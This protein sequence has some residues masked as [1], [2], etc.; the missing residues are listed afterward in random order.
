MITISP[1]SP[2]LLARILPA[3][4]AK[5][6][7]SVIHV[8][9]FFLRLLL[10]FLFYSYQSLSVSPADLVWRLHVYQRRSNFARSNTTVGGAGFKTFRDLQL[11]SKDNWLFDLKLTLSDYNKFQMHFEVLSVY[12]IVQWILN[13][14]LVLCCSYLITITLLFIFKKTQVASQYLLQS[15]FPRIDMTDKKLIDEV[16]II[17]IYLFGTAGYF[18]LG[19][20]RLLVSVVYSNI[21]G[22]QRSYWLHTRVPWY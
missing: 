7:Y 13:T 6:W 15:E 19:M 4:E 18:W 20:L 3:M 10:Y 22:A 21:L 11:L 16:R 17:I 8:F 12:G 1:C 5:T 2:R 14:G 9:L